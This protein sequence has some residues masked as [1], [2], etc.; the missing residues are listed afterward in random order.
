MASV[1]VLLTGRNWST[2]QLEPPSRK[3]ERRDGAVNVNLG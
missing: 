3:Q 1:S 2:G